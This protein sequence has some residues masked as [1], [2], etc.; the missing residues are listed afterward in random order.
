MNHLKWCINLFIEE[1]QT[2]WFFWLP[3]NSTTIRRQVVNASFTYSLSISV[4]VTCFRFIF[5][6]CHL[7][8]WCL[9]NCVILLIGFFSNSHFRWRLSKC[10]KKSIKLSWIWTVVGNG[11]KGAHSHAVIL[12]KLIIYARKK[13]HSSVTNTIAPLQRPFFG[14]HHL[15][16]FITVIE[17]AL[18]LMNKKISITNNKINYLLSMIFFFSIV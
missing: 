6:I 18:K 15:F 14:N 13:Y 17:R 3:I 11:R 5:V 7:R 2:I 10:G 8:L 4:A 9:M 16:L 1:I 12:M